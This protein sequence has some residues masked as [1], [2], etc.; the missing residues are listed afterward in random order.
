MADEHPAVG[1]FDLFQ[2]ELR[3]TVDFATVRDG[4]ADRR[5]FQELVLALARTAQDQQHK[6][7]WLQPLPPMRS[8]GVTGG[9]PRQQSVINR[10]AAQISAQ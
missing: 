1:I 9:A 5:K 6:S 7:D 2:L 3:V 10:V 4:V 8:A